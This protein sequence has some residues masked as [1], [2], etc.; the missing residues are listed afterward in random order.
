MDNLI[1]K[2]FGKLEVKSIDDEKAHCLCS[3]GRLAKIHIKNLLSGKRRT[4]GECLKNLDWTGRKQG[5]LY[6]KEKVSDNKWLAICDCG[7]QI[8]LNRRQVYGR[9]TCGCI[10]GGSIPKDYTDYKFNDTTVI[11]FIERD[12]WL[13]RCDLCEKEFVLT[14]GQIKN[15][16]RIKPCRCTLSGKAKIYKPGYRFNRLTIIKYTGKKNYRGSN[17]W[18]C[19][20]NCGNE[21]ELTSDQIYNNKKSCGC[22]N[23][24]DEVS[25]ASNHIY[26]QYRYGANRRNRVLTFELTREEFYKLTQKDCFYCGASPSQSQKAHPNFKYNGIDRV[27][28]T[29]GYTKDNCVPCCATCNFMKKKMSQEEFL[30]HMIRIL[31]NMRKKGLV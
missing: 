29:K 24:K 7:N 15:R 5:M 20:C 26:A 11:K 9:K 8:E 17:I 30:A 3:C 12:K 2:K 4:C 27:D 14:K 19:E 16:I 18:L 22:Y 21:I 28:D 1:G 10:K 6:I 31:K 23:G 13:C 25:R